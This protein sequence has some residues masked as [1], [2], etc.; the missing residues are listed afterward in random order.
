MSQGLKLRRNTC[1][2]WFKSSLAVKF[3]VPKPERMALSKRWTSIS[4]LSKGAHMTTTSSQSAWGIYNFRRLK[5]FFRKVRRN[6][7]S[8]FFFKLRFLK[9]RLLVTWLKCLIERKI[10][11]KQKTHLAT[12]KNF[13]LHHSLKINKLWCPNNLR[14]GRG[15]EKIRKINKRPPSL[16]GTKEDSKCN[17]HQLW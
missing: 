5:R 11:H 13:E 17:L 9:I 4:R 1:F 2:C 16:L 14:E 7:W 8:A 6:L 10:L 15:T 12:E 3:H